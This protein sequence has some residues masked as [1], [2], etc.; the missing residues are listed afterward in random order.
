MY[1]WSNQLKMLKRE[2][3]HKLEKNAKTLAIGESCHDGPESWHVWSVE[4]N[5]RYWKNCG[6]MDM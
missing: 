6:T 5:W 3:L 2:V 1:T 4:F